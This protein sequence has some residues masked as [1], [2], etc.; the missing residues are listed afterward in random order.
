MFRGV[1]IAMFEGHR[2]RVISSCRVSGDYFSRQDDPEVSQKVASCRSFIQ[3]RAGKQYR[4]D[5]LVMNYSYYCQTVLYDNFISLVTSY[6]RM[7]PS[8][9][10]SQVEIWLWLNELWLMDVYGRYNELVHGG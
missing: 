9:I 1:S 3:R 10:A 8:K 7:G 5:K 6:Y 2:D 4:M